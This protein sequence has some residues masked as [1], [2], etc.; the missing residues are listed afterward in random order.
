VCRSIGTGNCDGT[1]ATARGKEESELLRNGNLFDT[2]EQQVHPDWDALQDGGF[3]MSY[4]VGVDIGG[5]FTDTVVV[6]DDGAPTIGKASSTPP[7]FERGFIDAVA[8][9]AEN[10][11]LSL[12]DLLAQTTAIYHGST[13]GTN[14]LVENKIAKV[15]LITTRGHG[16]ALAMMQA[17]E[18]LI[19]EPPETIAHA[20]AHE[21]PEPLVPK[22]LIAE[23]DERIARDG[24]VI[25]PLREEEIREVVSAQIEQGVEAFAVSFLWSPVN[26]SHEETVKRVIEEV[27]PS[28]FVSLSSEVAPRPGEYKRTVA[29]VLNASIGP[30]MRSYLTRLQEE[31]ANEGYG[32]GLQ[33]MSCSGGLI[34]ADEARG[35]PVLTVGSGP[36][37]GVIGS[38]ALSKRESASTS[39]ASRAAGI[40]ATDTGGTTLDVALIYDG[41]GVP[42]PS[43][44]HG[45]YEY[46]VPTVDVRSVGAG[47][48]SII[49]FDQRFGSLR[50]GPRSAGARPGPACY[51]RGGSDPTVTDADVILG[52][53]NPQN[54]LDGKIELDV[55]AARA[56]LAKVG[57]PLGYGAEQ[58]AAAAVKILESQMADAIRLMCVQ[59]GYDTRKMLV[60]AYG[61]AG[62]VHA[63]GYA[64]DLGSPQ[65][66]VPMGNF[67][68]GWS[69]FGVSTSDA[70]LVRE[71]GISMVAPFDCET[72]NKHWTRLEGE[73][74]ERL[75]GQGIPSDAIVLDRYLDMK[76]V[77]QT[78]VLSV[79]APDGHYDESSIEAMCR[80]FDEEY[81]RRFGKGSSHPGAGYAV[82]GM[83]VHGRAALGSPS[84][85]SVS[86]TAVRKN[87]PEPVAHRDVLSY[88]VDDVATQRT[89]IFAGVELS[90]GAELA[91]PAII[92][93]PDTTVVVR[94]GH[95]ASI[96]E[97]DNV[98]I[99]L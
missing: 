16:D 33:L 82:N 71:A 54:F 72:M 35:R 53:L 50:V 59:Q 22:D 8:A 30:V 89:P 98:I 9:A 73:V 74:R 29:A 67:A 52:Y 41:K 18:R 21:K 13:I 94:K 62:P 23:V 36:V 87:E 64:Q 31:L 60:Y 43:S 32:G 20:A 4:L 90:A 58:V 25:V 75:E 56:A 61:G 27:A 55:E 65:I 26:S 97:M 42:R 15:G 80:A 57:E 45:Q 81:E 92:E 51:G 83:Q 69:A 24:N 11:G 2:A 88:Q 14:A 1:E 79:R 63:G 86:G 39:D 7:D 44:R 91:G 47:G 19:G 3:P 68:A 5:T 78:N 76:Y 28:A 38:A 70:L 12:G 48:G 99:T 40:I 49:W 84:L 6:D 17:G 37:A 77:I 95:R 96:D 93:Y 34:D 66:L 46:Y 85:T 10:L